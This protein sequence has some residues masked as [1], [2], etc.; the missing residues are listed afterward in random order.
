M[1]SEEFILAI[2]VA[3]LGSSGLAS[4]VVA[5][6]NRK[7]NK[8]DKDSN[9]YAAVVGALKILMYDKIHHLGS[10]CITAGQIDLEMKERLK[11]MHASYRELGG[12]GKLNTVMAEIEKLEIA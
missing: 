5:A 3:C 1:T 6:L 12:N 7:W 2:L 8:K 4:V 10:K 11:E 9:Q